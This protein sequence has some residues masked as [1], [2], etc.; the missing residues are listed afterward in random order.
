MLNHHEL[1]RNYPMILANLA[2]DLGANYDSVHST[3]SIANLF[4]SRELK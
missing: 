4:T 2:T 3:R 1:M